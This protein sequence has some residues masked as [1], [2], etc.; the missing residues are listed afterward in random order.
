M[1]VIDDVLGGID[2]GPTASAVTSLIDQ[3]GG[4]P[5]L[6]AHLEK[7]GLG[8]AVQVRAEKRG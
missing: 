4:L 1:Q 7:Q 5:G 3:H 6:I 2:G 8:A